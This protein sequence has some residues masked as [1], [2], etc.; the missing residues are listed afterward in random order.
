MAWTL[1]STTTVTASSAATISFTGIPQ[2]GKDLVV[3]MSARS[4][5]T[6]AQTTTSI[7]SNSFS[8]RVHLNGT[9]SAAASSSGS[10]NVIADTIVISTYTASTFSN[11]QIYISN[12]TSS[13]SKP[14]SFEAVTE[15]NATDAAQRIVA[16]RSSSTAAV[17][18]LEFGVSGGSFAQ[19]STISLYLVS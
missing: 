18:S 11:V 15:N 1:V 2:T 3:L 16:A 17:T 5:G 4:T 10:N 6:T 12:Y 7:N 8:T 19:H 9:G 14:I 13:V